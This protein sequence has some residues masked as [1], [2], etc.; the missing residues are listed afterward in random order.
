MVNKRKRAR[1][2]RRSPWESIWP[3]LGL[4]VLIA[5]LGSALGWLTSAGSGSGS[6]SGNR[7]PEPTPEDA[8]L[9]VY[10]TPR[11]RCCSRWVEYLRRAG[12]EVE[13]IDVADTGPAQVRMGIPHELRSCHTAR[14]G[15]YWV[16]GHVPADLVEQLL[17]D[18]PAGIIGLAVPGMPVGSPG[19]EGPDPVIYEV[20]AV[21]SEGRH[22]I[23]ATREGKS[24][25]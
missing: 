16:E 22:R 23:H 19:M 2:S 18:R 20:I 9:V 13:V 25:P 8:E 10:K 11:C 21:D 14:V 15:R 4:L 7:N 5:G 1:K 17:S 3:W 24:A 12:L 6:G